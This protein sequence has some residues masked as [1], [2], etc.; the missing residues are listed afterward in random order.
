MSSNYFHLMPCSK[1]IMFTFQKLKLILQN[2]IM[3]LF[4]LVLALVSIVARVIQL[5]TFI[6]LFIV[7]CIVL[8]CIIVFFQMIVV[9]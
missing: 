9:F 8:S 7:L 3:A 6:K 5:Y 4:Q 2:P 1:L